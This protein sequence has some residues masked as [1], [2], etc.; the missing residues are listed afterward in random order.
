MQWWLGIIA[1]A[2]NVLVYRQVLKAWK[3]RQGK[4]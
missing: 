2:I 4:T 1:V 3:E